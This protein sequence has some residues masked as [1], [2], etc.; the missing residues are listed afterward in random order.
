MAVVR[1]LWSFGEDGKF[2]AVPVT[3]PNAGD[4]LLPV[5]AKTSLGSVSALNFASSSFLDLERASKY[6]ERATQGLSGRKLI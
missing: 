5:K 3:G 2:T 6:A 4:R 1:H